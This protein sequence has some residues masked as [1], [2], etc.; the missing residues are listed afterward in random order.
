MLQEYTLT[1]SA[2]ERDLEWKSVFRSCPTKSMTG[3]GS[4]KDVADMS[5]KEENEGNYI[6]REV[7]KKYEKSE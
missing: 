3:S 6:M 2:S 7:L 1:R 4:K 5:E